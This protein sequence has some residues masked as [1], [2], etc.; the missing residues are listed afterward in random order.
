MKYEI[1][2]K[3]RKLREAKNLSQKEFARLIG[4][5]NSR[6][7]NWEMGINRPDVDI[8][9][10][11]CDVLEVSAD[12]LLDL[13]TSDMGEWSTPLV[14]AYASAIRPTQEAAC[15][16]LGIPYVKPDPFY[17][18]EVATCDMLV[19]TF[20][21]AA[22]IPLSA[23]DDY[24]RIEFPTS[25]VPAGADFGVRIRGDSMQPTIP[26]GTIVFVRKQP[27]MQ[28]GQI[29]IFMI[30]D[31]ALCKRFYRRGEQVFLQ[32]DNPKYKDIEVGEHERLFIVGKVLGYR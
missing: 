23:E 27:E 29:G 16:V 19:Y 2:S 3:I 24:E 10:T 31:G 9:S 21:A 30:D 26:D 5:S 25:E 7:S 32:S 22:G 12:A 15:A 17:K 8:L 14:S 13:R 11:I 20:P 1:G 4:V 6:V 28:N 18:P